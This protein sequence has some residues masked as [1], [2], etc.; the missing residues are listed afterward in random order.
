MIFFF[1]LILHNLFSSNQEK[2]VF[3]IPIGGPLKE[4]TLQVYLPTGR[5][6]QMPIL[7][8]SV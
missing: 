5:Y 3:F 1:K 8:D 4:V 6:A 2:N 7:I